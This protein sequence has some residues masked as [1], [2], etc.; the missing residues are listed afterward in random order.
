MSHNPVTLDY[1]WHVTNMI[2]VN[3]TVSNVS[4]FHTGRTLTLL[5]AKT[6]LIHFILK[7]VRG[8]VGD[9]RHSAGTLSELTYLLWHSAAAT[10]TLNVVIGGCAALPVSWLCIRTCAGLFAIR[11]RPPLGSEGAPVSFCRDIIITQ[12]CRHNGAFWHTHTQR[13]C[14]LEASSMVGFASR[15]PKSE[16]ICVIHIVPC[17]TNDLIIHMWS[18]LT[19]VV[20]MG[21]SSISQVCATDHRC[22][23]LCM[24]ETL[25]HY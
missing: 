23:S 10:D 15:G 8:L 1:L 24:W 17:D 9:Q 21:H 25:V 14:Y 6:L 16:I 20:W 5:S 4:Y 18:E 13:K 19:S 7:W 3:N 12:M 22:V 11:H 2:I